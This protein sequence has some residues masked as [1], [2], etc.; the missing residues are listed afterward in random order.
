MRLRFTDN[1]HPLNLFDPDTTGTLPPERYE[2]I[3]EAT[4]EE[5][6]TD[7]NKP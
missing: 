2:F 5:V 3:L 4:V 7:M 6:T 1:L